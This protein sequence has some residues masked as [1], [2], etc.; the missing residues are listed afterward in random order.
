MY[1]HYPLL[2]GGRRVE[3][4]KANSFPS[5]NPYNGE[6]WATI[7]QADE[8]D[9]RSAVSIARHVFETV[10]RRVPGVERARLL[11]R[12]ADLLERN[13]DR[14][15]LMESKDNGKVIRET[16]G[17][18]TFAARQYRFFAGFADKLWGSV[19]PLD[20]NDVFDYAARE[21][22][23]VAALITAWNSP[24]QLLSN[25]LAPALAAG[26]C[27]VIK[28][29]EHASVTTVE[30]GRL[31]EE[32]GFPPGV[33]NIVTGDGRVGEALVTAEGINR[34][35]FTGS[36]GVG[37]AIA[38]SA[39]RNLVPVT[40]ELG[41]KSPNIVFAD[42]DFDKAVVGALAGIFGASGQTC[43]AGS[44]LL[45]QRPI[46]DAMVDRLDQRAKAIVLGDPTDP[47]TEMGTVANAPQFRRILDCISSARAEGARLVTGGDPAT[48]GDLARGLFIKPTIFA[49]V[50]NDM[51][52][53]QEEIF[54]PVLA[55]IPFDSEEEAVEI[56]NST[57]Y[58]LAAGIWTKDISRAM[59]VSRAIKA[60]T[61]WVNTYRAVA[62]Q[63]PFGGTKESG[64]GRERGQQALD[65][66]MT[67]K[68]VMIDF[69]DAVRDPFA[70][71]A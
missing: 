46:Y 4:A 27:V 43:I 49:E 16:R 18:M 55:I 52:I 13:A 24:M 9:V 25:K 40:L 58:G 51:K 23:G 22:L 32:A 20:Q 31:V 65:E 64:F 37:R 21:P 42:A 68:N 1:P 5:V 54:G 10:W 56:G 36:P 70:I 50:H 26:N 3:G 57:R 7:A 59:R 2:I 48:D 12:L 35:S 11:N 14:F 15:S 63:A 34:V 62:C 61:V 19:I 60:G 44:R 47:A 69:S 67:Y 38:A 66:F 53:A 29:S 8:S 33:V 17:Q 39:G 28:P 45:V 6:T 30:F 41:G 71:K